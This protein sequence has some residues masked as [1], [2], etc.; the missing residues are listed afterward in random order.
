MVLLP[1][2]IEQPITLYRQYQSM[3]IGSVLHTTY[4]VSEPR[5]DQSISSQLRVYSS[6]PDLVDRLSLTDQ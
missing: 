1:N 5:Q 4:S 6:N 2:C 3:M